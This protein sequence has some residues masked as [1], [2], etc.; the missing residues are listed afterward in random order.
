MDIIFCDSR[1][2]II[3]LCYS[4]SISRLIR[5]LIGHFSPLK[6]KQKETYFFVMFLTFKEIFHSHSL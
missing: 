3:F 1:M 6:D 5:V 4:S 2:D